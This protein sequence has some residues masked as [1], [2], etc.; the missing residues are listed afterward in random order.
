MVSSLK[1]CVCVSVKEEGC[2]RATATSSCVEGVRVI[3]SIRADLLTG[4]CSVVIYG[5]FQL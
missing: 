5:A 4:S 3:E 2:V 1:V